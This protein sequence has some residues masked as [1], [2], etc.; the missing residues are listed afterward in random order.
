MKVAVTGAM[1]LLGH[2]L[3]RQLRQLP[4]MEPLPTARP[5][6]T[7]PEGIIPLDITDRAAVIDFFDRHRPAV[8]VNCAAMTQVDQ[9]ETDRE[10]C[11]LNNVTA[12][13]YLLQAAS[14]TQ[15]HFIHL[16]T[17]FIFDGS[18][19][20]LD[21]TAVPRPINYYGE[22]KWAAEQRVRHSNL[23]WAIL[24]TVLVYGKPAFPGR[25]NIVTWVKESLESRKPIRVVNDQWR[26]PTFVNDLAAAC[27]LAIR[28]KATGVYHI[29]G[30]ELMTPYD[31][32]MRVAAFFELDTQLITATDITGFQQ[33]AQ[34]PPRT[35]FIIAKAKR[36]LGFEPRT[37]EEG[38]AAL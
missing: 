10:A 30:E 6:G 13:D 11:W 19:G 14:Q 17:D 8:I 28:K 3:T 23:P 5:R 27:V 1:G 26:T 18:H 38:L 4:R 32:A 33:P 20:P 9:C 36:E 34:R 12:V 35:G 7:L 21:E 25:A 2:E 15:T 24:R 22:S 37:L 31:L 29:S 16:S